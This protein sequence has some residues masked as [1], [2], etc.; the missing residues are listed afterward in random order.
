MTRFIR[1]LAHA[2]KDIVRLE[3]PKLKDTITGAYVPNALSKIAQVAEAYHQARSTAPVKST[4]FRAEPVSPLDG[5]EV[6]LYTDRSDE[7]LKSRAADL[8]PMTVRPQRREPHPMVAAVQSWYNPPDYAPSTFTD[9][10][11]TV[12]YS[13][14]DVDPSADPYAQGTTDWDV[15]AIGYTRVRFPPRTQA[16]AP[17]A[18][19]RKL[20]PMVCFRCFLANHIASNC[21]HKARDPNNPEFQ[22]WSRTNFSK[23]PVWQ[24]M[25]LMSID[26]VPASLSAESRQRL[27][28]HSEAS[29]PPQDPSPSPVTTPDVVPTPSAQ[30]HV[31][32]K[33]MQRPME[34]NSTSGN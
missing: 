9:F 32:P 15:N 22:R 23:L 3:L 20:I 18:P 7:S 4:R 33:I 30:A 12:E 10:T 2:I 6:P 1:N 14:R 21:P 31:A 28:M 17:R 13:V 27:A 5:Q 24:L 29:A 26:R 34:P 25:W 19:M 16:P 8:G 11:P